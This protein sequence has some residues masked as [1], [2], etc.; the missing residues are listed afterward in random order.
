MESK[1][2]CIEV[3]SKRLKELRKANGYTIEQF[4]T[5][6]GISK[7][8]VG[9]YESANRLPDV[10]IL[11][12]IADALNVPADYLIGRTNTA[13]QKGKMK[14]VC[15]LTGLSD[16]AAEYLAQLVKDKDRRKLSV[17]NHLFEHLVEC[18]DTFVYEFDSGEE[19]KSDILGALFLYFEHFT[20]WENAWE[21]YI[22]QGDVERDK[23]LA[24]A[25]RQH[26]LNRVTNAVD[27]SVE[28]YKQEHKPWESRK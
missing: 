3:F 5:L 15:E 1:T 9:Y 21:D 16:G 26:L 8:S 28:I 4:A 22:V 14:T 6:V 11:S 27:A 23:V 25:Y 18:C 13:T 20:R 19:V 10:G 12:R 24:A 17:I 7:S 2:T